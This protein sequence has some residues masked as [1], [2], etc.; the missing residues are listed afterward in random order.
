MRERDEARDG[1][2]NAAYIHLEDDKGPAG[3]GRLI[4]ATID[5]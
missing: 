1:D 5:R 2:K 3:V 4:D